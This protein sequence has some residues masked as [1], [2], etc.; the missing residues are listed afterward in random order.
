MIPLTVT[1][2]LR[3][4][5]LLFGNFVNYLILLFVLQVQFVIKG[6]NAF[7][8][9]SQGR[10][11]EES[12][13]GGTGTTTTTTT[14]SIQIDDTINASNTSEL[15]IGVINFEESSYQIE[16]QQSQPQEQ[17]QQ[18]NQHEFELV[19]P[20][21]ISGKLLK[22]EETQSPDSD[23]SE[24]YGFPTLRTSLRPK[25]VSRQSCGYNSGSQ[26]P[27]ADDWIDVSS[28][29]SEYSSSSRIAKMIYSSNAFTTD[30]KITAISFNLL[31]SYLEE[32]GD[33]EMCEEDLMLICQRVIADYDTFVKALKDLPLFIKNYKYN[34]NAVK[35]NSILYSYLSH[36][37]E[38]FKDILT[39]EHMEHGSVSSRCSS[40]GTDSTIDSPP[41]SPMTDSFNSTPSICRVR[42]SSCSPRNED[43]H[44][45]SI[46]RVL[47][48][49]NRVQSHVPH[50][51][52]PPLVPNTLGNF[53]F[54]YGNHASYVPTKLGLKNVHTMRFGPM[55]YPLQ[56]ESKTRTLSSEDE[57]VT[58]IEEID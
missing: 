17:Q 28:Q 3:M 54:A 2:I 15:D 33:K 22:L 23:V 53:A 11:K 35:I 44:E 18:I 42:N 13:M 26:T 10:K 41:N 37:S 14:T 46:N 48:E 30:T 27:G 1:R 58:A 39:H 19:V 50:V 29:N 16:Q 4:R 25:S 21:A 52:Q 31:C 34:Q 47:E 8:G 7:P 49:I 56:E 6:S 9:N 55:L 43:D 57:S 12:M 40:R 38:C 51:P 5:R 24:N 45:N 36:S 20:R 32:T